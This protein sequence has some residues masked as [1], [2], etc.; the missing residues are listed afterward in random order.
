MLFFEHEGY[1]MYFDDDCKE[2]PLR[3]DTLS[4]SPAIIDLICLLVN[5]GLDGETFIRN[6]LAALKSPSDYMGE[7]VKKRVLSIIRSQAEESALT[8][9]YISSISSF[10]DTKKAEFN[11]VDG[12]PFDTMDDKISSS[13]SMASISFFGDFFGSIM[14]AYI[15]ECLNKNN[16]ISDVEEAIINALNDV[17]TWVN[18]LFAPDNPCIEGHQLFETQSIQFK[19]LPFEHG[20]IPAFEIDNADIPSLIVILFYELLKFK[21]TG[22]RLCECK[23]CR[24]MFSPSLR[25]EEVYCMHVNENG[26]TCK[27]VGYENTMDNIDKEYRKAQKTKNAYK[28]R[29]LK[30]GNKSRG[31]VEKQYK[32]WLE[33]ASEMKQKVRGGK[34]TEQEFYTFLKKGLD[35]VEGVQF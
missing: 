12:I 33:T 7:S 8:D 29:V 17:V 26:K 27:E 3:N 13:I 32:K 20:F 18:S 11:K 16:V 9:D 31:T 28:N 30:I 5:M 6:Y 4:R 24:R 25:K 15:V 19:I 35:D 10:L 22:K 2:Y 23:N 1:W 14:N 21:Q 34:I